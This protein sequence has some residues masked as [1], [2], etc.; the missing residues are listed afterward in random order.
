MLMAFLSID[1]NIFFATLNALCLD[2]APVCS[3]KLF[4]LQDV[5]LNAPL[6]IVI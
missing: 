5:Q 4:R 1:D 3:D 6:T 2:W